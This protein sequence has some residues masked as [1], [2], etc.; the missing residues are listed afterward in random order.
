[1]NFLVLVTYLLRMEGNIVSAKHTR[2]YRHCGQGCNIRRKRGI[3]RFRRNAAIAVGSILAMAVGGAGDARDHKVGGQ[4][5]FF[6]L[7]R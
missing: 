6:E 4:S 3:F 2:E 1:M 7:E 5:V